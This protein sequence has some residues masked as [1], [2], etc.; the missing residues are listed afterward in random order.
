MAGLDFSCQG[1][2][3]DGR[4]LAGAVP[5]WQYAPQ[6]WGYPGQAI[7]YFQG[8]P[9]TPYA[10]AALGAPLQGGAD[11]SLLTGYDEVCGAPG[12]AASPDLVAAIAA[13]L[14]QQ[15]ER[16]AALTASQMAVDSVNTKAKRAEPAYVIPSGGVAAP[17]AAHVGSP[18][19]QGAV[20]P[21]GSP[22]ESLKG[23]PQNDH[24]TLRRILENLRDK[25][26][27]R[28]FV[29]R[30][31]NKL[32]FRSG[33][34]LDRHF[35]R[36]GEV[37]QVLVAHSKANTPPP[38]GEAAARRR[39]GNLGLVVMKRVEEVQRIFALGQE[40]TVNGVVVSVQAFVPPSGKDKPEDCIADMTENDEPSSGDGM[41]SDKL[42][43]VKKK[44]EDWSGS[45]HSHG[46]HGSHGSTTCASDNNR[47][48][49]GNAEI[50]NNTLEWQ[51]QQTD[52]SS[53]EGW[54]S[55]AWGRQET[56]SS[57]ATA[58]SSWEESAEA[59]AQQAERAEEAQ[60]SSQDAERNELRVA[61]ENITGIIG[62]SH[63]G[64]MS[65]QQMQETVSLVKWAK[66]KFSAIESECQQTA[67]QMTKADSA[68]SRSSQLQGQQMQRHQPI[69]QASL[70]GQQFLQQKHLFLHQFQAEEV[71]RQAERQDQERKQLQQRQAQEQNRL[72]KHQAK[73]MEKHSR[74]EQHQQQQR[75][76]HQ[77][78]QEQ[79]QQQHHHQ[80]FA[81]Q[82]QQQLVTNKLQ[83]IAQQLQG[84]GGCLAMHQSESQVTAATVMP[85]MHSLC[86]AQSAQADAAQALAQI[87]QLQKQV[88]HVQQRAEQLAQIQIL[89]SQ[90]R[91]QQARSTAESH[92]GAQAP[93]QAEGVR[94]GSTLRAH[95]A[96]LHSEDPSHVLVA[97][98]INKLGFRSREILTKY[99]SSS[100]IA[101]RVL[102]AHRKDNSRPCSLGLIVMK[103]KDDVEQVLSWGSQQV[104]NGVTM[105]V[106]RFMWP[107]DEPKPVPSSSSAPGSDTSPG[108][109]TNSAAPARPTRRVRP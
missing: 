5:A 73:V 98:H 54:E 107:A 89:Q 13:G 103:S 43:S 57:R 74:Q 65:S 78:H 60:G 8:W 101:A 71:H 11:L 66:V 19:V 92:K 77:Q 88:L 25:D 83:S 108:S 106:E 90:Q 105:T 68:Q 48:P 37:D 94:G 4:G 97:R 45:S 36:Y 29:V 84:L 51:R 52:S 56:D 22:T 27:Q 40:Q 7:D 9:P 70:H 63:L 87:A 86:A 104:V 109:D 14:R 41:K 32:G 81:N 69:P 67:A 91:P 15:S 59:V 10:A 82:Q 33:K 80:Q 100:G 46:S 26:P 99:F 96:A 72:L 64:Q 21:T 38:N 24:E 85:T 58:S 49:R 75:K 55:S 12:A 35:K 18:P 3:T 102:V 76:R 42:A 53:A 95:L 93:P 2:P 61:L 50:F 30:R 44:G 6:T 31:I 39:P 47:S 1:T 62:S 28:I 20:T 34:A 23:A 79:E 17:S 16:L